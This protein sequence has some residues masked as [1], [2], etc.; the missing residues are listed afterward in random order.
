MFPNYAEKYE[1]G[2]IECIVPA[3]DK[4]ILAAICDCV[5]SASGDFKAEMVVDGTNDPLKVSVEYRGPKSEAFKIF[6]GLRE[7]GIYPIVYAVKE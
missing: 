5:N 1:T 4:H 2:R 6:S 3:G 7:I